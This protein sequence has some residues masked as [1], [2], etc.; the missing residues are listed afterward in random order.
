MNEAEP[1]ING[2]R[3]TPPM[4]MMP[5]MPSMPTMKVTL[6]VVPGCP[7]CASARAWLKSHGVEYAER[8]VA[9]DFG[10]LRAM[11]KLTKQR[12]VPVFE[13]SGRAL[14]RPTEAELSELL[15]EAN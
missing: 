1:I 5:T 15:L 11:H 9:N 14:V 10:A 12:F 7:L 8:D 13:A 2:T 6:Y 4:P 3:P